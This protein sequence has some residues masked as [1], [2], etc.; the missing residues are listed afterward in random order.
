M[1]WLM[2]EHAQ[3]ETLQRAAAKRCPVPDDSDWLYRRGEPA[4]YMTIVLTGLLMILV[5]RDG[6]QQECGAFTVLG[7]DSLADSEDNIPYKTDFSAAVWS[8]T[9]RIV[10]ISKAQ[11][12]EARRLEALDSIPMLEPAINE[13]IQRAVFAREKTRLLGAEVERAGKGKRGG[14][15]NS[16]MN[17]AAIDTVNAVSPSSTL[18]RTPLKEQIKD[19]DSKDGKLGK[20]SGTAASGGLLSSIFARKKVPHRA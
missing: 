2:I 8:D 13:R 10:K 9:V 6:F 7:I 1:L 12:D 5:G 14:M 17:G 4:G 18:A 11:Y 20:P 19:K 16:Q 3:V 15:R